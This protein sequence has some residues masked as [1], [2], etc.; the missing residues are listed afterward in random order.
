MLHYY[1]EEGLID[2]EYWSPN[3]DEVDEEDPDWSDDAKPITRKTKKVKR[4]RMGRRE[5][6][7]A[8]TKELKCTQCDH[9]PFK[10]RTELK[11]HLKET[12]G[13]EGLEKLMYKCTEVDCTFEG[14]TQ[15][16]LSEHKEE[17]HGISP[18]FKC[19]VI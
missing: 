9:E 12:H 16:L 1:L 6:N 13:G 4:T 19:R 3:G 2:E 8:K 11:E 7:A 10:T 17:V 5:R 15:K 14:V 18:S